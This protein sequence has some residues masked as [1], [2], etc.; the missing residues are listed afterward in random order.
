MGLT[1]WLSQYVETK[2]AA[3]NAA[4]KHEPDT[5]I[6]NFSAKKLTLAGDVEYAVNAK[7]MMHFPD[8]DSSELTGVEL[9]A[10]QPGKPRAV[11]TAPRGELIRRS[12]GSDEVLMSGGV[13]IESDGLGQYPPMKIRTQNLHAFPDTGI[14][15]STSRTEM[16]TDQVYLVANQFE[17]NTI[18]ESARFQ[19]VKA[20]QLPKL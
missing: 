15:R 16:M 4:P 3:R 14:I 6:E 5:I 9:I 20:V 18:E 11:L 17:I 10:T 8:N 1:F 7:Q 13:L 12:D 2:P 19:R